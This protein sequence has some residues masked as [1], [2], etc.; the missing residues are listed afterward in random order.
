MSGLATVSVVIPCLNRAHFLIPTIES[1]LN[2]S[3]PNI[4]CI[5][6]DGGSTDGTVEI[7]KHYENRLQWVSEQDNGHADA[8]NKGWKM[9]KGEI[10]A[11]LNADDVWEVPGAVGHAVDYLSKHPEADVV[12]GKC[13]AIDEDGR[14][15]GMSYLHEWDLAYA[16]EYCD[17]CISQPA[18]FIRR[19]ALERVGWLDTAFLSKKDHELW[20]RLGLI[21]HIHYTPV[22]LASA[23]ACP[24]YLSHR[25]D[26]TARACVDLTKKFFRLPSVPREIMSKKQRAISNAYVRGI[27]YAWTDGRKWL[28]I[29]TFTMCALIHDWSNRWKIAGE[30]LGRID[31]AAKENRGWL[32]VSRFFNSMVA[33]WGFSH[34]LRK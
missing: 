2:Q 17:H 29:F 23:R 28:T 7:L 24:G 13:G 34:R 30:F 22:I 5:V 3:Y 1:V 32:P 21:G 4:E 19:T 25:G 33:L 16:V 11:W 18:A 8:I 14:D 9:S 15:V 31:L 12:Y 26:I 6:I 27:Q 20:L 10:L